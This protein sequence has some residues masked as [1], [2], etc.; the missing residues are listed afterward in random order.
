MNG[1]NSRSGLSSRPR[2]GDNNVNMKEWQRAHFK[3]TRGSFF[4][5]IAP[6]GGLLCGEWWK[7]ASAICILL[8]I[9][10][11]HGVWRRLTG[12]VLWISVVFWGSSIENAHNGV[13]VLP[14]PVLLFAVCAFYV[15]WY[16]DGQKRNREE[17][18]K[19]DEWS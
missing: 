8:G 9:V 19:K 13:G 2:L 10:L 5:F 4:T 15:T 16:A 17:D 6:L 12:I 7:L 14:F 3:V 11:S 18:A 1:E